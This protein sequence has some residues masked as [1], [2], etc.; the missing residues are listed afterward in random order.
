MFA[1]SIQG[2]RRKAGFALIIALLT[3]NHLLAEN[4]F[5]LKKISDNVILVE[6]A[7]TDPIA[8]FQFSINAGGGIALQAFEGT[9]RTFGAGLAIYQYLKDGS[10]LNVVLLAPF[11]SSLSAGQ[12]VIGKVSFEPA[13]GSSADSARVSLT[14]VVICSADAKELDATA[15]QLRWSLR[16]NNQNASTSFRLEQNYPNPFSA[17]GG[18]AFGGNPSTTITYKLEKPAQVQLVIYDIIGREVR[19]LVHQQQPEGQYAVKWNAVDDEGSVLPSGMY[20]ARLKVRDEV[21][22]KKLL[23]MK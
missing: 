20:V 14:N 15:E 17:R 22:T 4:R 19:T 3:S 18:S 13:S 23:L 2:I 5:S 1:N 6:L 16:Q 12:G 21:A 7:N 9:E 8:G 10:T 11:R